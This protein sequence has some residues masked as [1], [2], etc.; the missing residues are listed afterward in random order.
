MAR[1]LK[2]CIAAISSILG[3]YY[4][5]HVPVCLWLWVFHAAVSWPLWALAALTGQ[6]QGARCC[7]ARCRGRRSSEPK[8]L[9]SPPFPLGK[10]GDGEPY[11]FDAAGIGE[12]RAG[13]VV[14]R[15]GT[16]LQYQVIEGDS[17]DAPV[18]LFCNG[19]GGFQFH[20]YR[21]IIL[22]YGAKFT[23]ITWDYRGLFGSERPTS[24]RRLAVSEHA[25][26][27]ADVLEACGRTRADVL[28]GWSMGVQVGLEVALLYPEKVGCLVLVNGAHGQVFHSA[29]Q[30]VVRLPILHDVVR[31][32]FAYAATHPWIL[33]TLRAMSLPLI[34]TVVRLYVW[35]LG[36]RL[37]KHSQFFGKRYMEKTLVDLL[38]HLC[39][40]EKTMETYLWLFQELNAHSVYH[41]L[42]SVHQQTLLISGLFDVLLPPY[43]MWEMERQM[44][45]ARHVCDRWSSHFT[46]LEHPEVV[47][48]QLQAFLKEQGVL[49]AGAQPGSP[50]P[51]KAAARQ[52]TECEE[53]CQQP[54]TE[55]GKGKEGVRQS[56]LQ[57]H[58]RCLAA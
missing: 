20:I 7:P 14:A 58:Q 35:L 6:Q 11:E 26:D 4:F 51:G 3:S 57:C 37:L 22:H 19:L 2:A 45:H 38:N 13:E 47:L 49:E 23:Y 30:P 46:L 1:L 40:D 53:C 48:R 12:I 41:L 39:D 33:R 5:V 32:A 34:P 8:P 9:P 54:C 28:I 56:E 29:L 16:R 43:H 27:A 42:G 18:M 24:I 55:A 36:S 15:D 50:S 10:T 17:D 25:H 31:A 21:P 44:P 52:R